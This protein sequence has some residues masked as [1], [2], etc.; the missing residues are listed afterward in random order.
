MSGSTCVQ[1]GTV[2][3]A[4]NVAPAHRSRSERYDQRTGRGPGFRHVTICGSTL[5]DPVSISGTTGAVTLGYPGFSCAS[6]QLSGPLTV[7]NSAGAVTIAGTHFT[8][9]ADTRDDRRGE[10][11]GATMNGPL[12]L[13]TNSGPL[14]LTGTA[15]EGP[16]TMSGHR[17]GPVVI[18]GNTVAGAVS[19]NANTASVAPVV[20][21][22]TLNTWSRYTANLPPP[23][24]GG[25]PNIVSG[26]ATAQC[27]GLV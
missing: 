9:T 15:I 2:S 5:A 7:S 25:A 27:A 11:S 8:G 1:G 6:D 13:G 23:V 26:K 17:D 18:S 14:T 21:A 12:Q 3:G 16:L 24:D 10:P 22:N 19:V 4:I 20:S